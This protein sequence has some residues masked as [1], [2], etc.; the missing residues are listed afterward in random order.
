ML[1]PYID[2]ILSEHAFCVVG[3]A[4]KIEQYAD[5]FNRVEK[6]K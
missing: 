1:A 4:A 2:A 5:K 3:S 6:L